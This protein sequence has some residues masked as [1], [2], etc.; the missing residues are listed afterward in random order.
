MVT[1]GLMLCGFLLGGVPFGWLLAKW[2]GVD[3]R[4][5]G[6]G[7]IGATNV[8]RVAGIKLGVLTLGLDALKGWAPTYV[9]WL[10]A[11]ERL[12]AGMGCASVLGHVFSP[13]LAFKG[14]KGVATALGVFGVLDPW[15]LMG[16]VGVFVLATLASKVVALGSISAAV[17]LPFFLFLSGVNSRVWM[18]SIGVGLLVLFRHA[19]NLTSMFSSDGTADLGDSRPGAGDPK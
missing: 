11:G 5:E 9:G 15:G 4:A 8:G 7:N 14:G 2:V 18:L 10:V 17:V 13:Y 6:S 3:V 19:G 16:A 1:V 12:A